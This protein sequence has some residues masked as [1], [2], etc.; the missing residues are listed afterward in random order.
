[1]GNTENIEK[2]NVYLYADTVSN[3]RNPIFVAF[4]NI[5]DVEYYY[6]NVLNKPYSD[7]Y[8][9]DEIF[10]DKWAIDPNITT[11]VSFSYRY[12]YNY[13]TYREDD[14]EHSNDMAMFNFDGSANGRMNELERL[15]YIRLALNDYDGKKQFM[16]YKYDNTI[17][18]KIVDNSKDE[19]NYWIKNLPFYTI[20]ES[21]YVLK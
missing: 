1:M 7:T 6:T 20:P 9:Y 13:F 19:I 4:K 16:E 8:L 18:T 15:K 11:H 14:A 12:V 10:V 5:S 21:E 2:M 17:I 3:S